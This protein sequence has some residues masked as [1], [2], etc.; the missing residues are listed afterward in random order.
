[1]DVRLDPTSSGRQLDKKFKNPSLVG[2]VREPHLARPGVPCAERDGKRQRAG[3]RRPIKRTDDAT[4]SGVRGKGALQPQVV[5]STVDE[6]PGQP[7]VSTGRTLLLLRTAVRRE[8]QTNVKG[9]RLMPA[10]IHRRRSAL[11]FIECHIRARSYHW[12][13]KNERW[14]SAGKRSTSAVPKAQGSEALLLASTS[15]FA[16]AISSDELVGGD[17]RRILLTAGASG[18]ADRRRLVDCSGLRGTEL[19]GPGSERS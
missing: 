5:L 7:S 9:R 4:Q 10:G 17:S 2:D 14:P 11:E 19:D 6:S 12:M 18:E 8:R 16:C 15:P 13:Q 1:V 3:V